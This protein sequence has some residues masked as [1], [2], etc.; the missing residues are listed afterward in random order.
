[1]I[2]LNQLNQ[3]V[4]EEY[5]ARKEL[6]DAKDARAG[7]RKSTVISKI[8]IRRLPKIAPKTWG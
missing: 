7:G 6:T 2:E 3:V 8:I 4:R 5:S 1:M